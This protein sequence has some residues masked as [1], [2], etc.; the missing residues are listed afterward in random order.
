MKSIDSFDWQEISQ[1]LDS[2]GW[3]VLSG[4]LAPAECRATAS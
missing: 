3:A 2:E 1:S 4:L